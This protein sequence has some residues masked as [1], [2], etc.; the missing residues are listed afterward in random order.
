MG[1]VEGFKRGYWELSGGVIVFEII[2]WKGMKG[3]DFFE[4]VFWF[5]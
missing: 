3:L 2:G 1:N 5:F 4:F